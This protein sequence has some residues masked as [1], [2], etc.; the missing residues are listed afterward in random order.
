MAGTLNSER[1][2]HGVIEGHLASSS[3][4]IQIRSISGWEGT[5]LWEHPPAGSSV[6]SEDWSLLVPGVGGR[7]ELYG[8]LESRGFLDLGSSEDRHGGKASKVYD[9]WGVRNCTLTTEKGCEGK[10]TF[11]ILER[12]QHS[13]LSLFALGS[14]NDTAAP[15]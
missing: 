8:N 12:L 14:E 4:Q 7:K 13:L 10:E 9:K 2:W 15:A 5:G 11:D 6:G 3:V 1:A